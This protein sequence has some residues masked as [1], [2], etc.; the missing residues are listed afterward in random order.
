MRV[1]CLSFLAAC[2]I[3]GSSSFDT[4]GTRAPSLA[5]LDD[6]SEVGDTW[7]EAGSAGEGWFC[8]Q[9]FTA[10]PWDAETDF[11]LVPTDFA[12]RV[13]GLQAKSLRWDVGGASELTIVTQQ[14]GLPA[15]SEPQLVGTLPDYVEEYPCQSLLQIPFQVTFETADGAFEEAWDVTHVVSRDAYGVYGLEPLLV[16]WERVPTDGLGG[17][18]DASADDPVGASDVVV[19]AGEASAAGTGGSIS[20]WGLDDMGRDTEVARI[21]VW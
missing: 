17:D 20:L 16:L 8:E 10:V 7:T 13:I 3:Q 11:D 14:K 5:P 18:Y 4:G 2:G 19:F 21:G 15:V 1:I 12:D 9:N 6:D